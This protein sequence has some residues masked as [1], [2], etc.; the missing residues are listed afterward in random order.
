MHFGRFLIEQRAATQDQVLRAL[1]EQRRSIPF[2]GELA[3]REGLLTVEQVLEI[4]DRQ[5][6][7]HRDFGE[8]GMLL[9]YL[10]FRDYRRLG[11]LKKE[12]FVPIG[13]VLVRQG[14]MSQKRMFQLLKEHLE[15]E[16]KRRTP[17]T[18]EVGPVN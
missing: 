17:A 2:I 15:A 11:E 18:A 4:L 12:A 13:E 3:V 5:L 10:D 7:T 1:D 16:S 9:G 8:Q 14:V 6:A